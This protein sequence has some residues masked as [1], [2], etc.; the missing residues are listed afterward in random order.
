MS[1]P[2]VHPAALSS[3]QLLAAC[4]VRRTRRSGPGGQHRNKVET[5]VVITHQPTGVKGQASQRR[6]QSQNLSAAVFR[7]R[8]N[9]ALAVRTQHGLEGVPSN[10]WLCRVVGGRIAIRLQH[11]DFPT[12]L[13]E[14]LDVLAACD[15]DV[16]RSAAALRCTPSQ[17]TKFLKLEPRALSQINA[18]RRELGLRLLR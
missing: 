1:P 8:V 3:A 16:Q 5:A 15:L 4:D 7:L 13:A 18:R 6:S 11:D 12:L 17:L 9:L 10:G 14:A 2:V